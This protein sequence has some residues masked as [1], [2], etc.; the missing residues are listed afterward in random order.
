MF[1]NILPTLVG[2]NSDF[3]PDFLVKIITLDDK[4]FQMLEKDLKHI[5]LL[6]IHGEDDKIVPIKYGKELFALSLANDKNLWVI[7]NCDHVQGILY[8]GLGTNPWH[9]DVRTRLVEY[10]DGRF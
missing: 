5:P 4:K 1:R 10:L 9:P 6:V 3:V 7:P 8:D 2:A